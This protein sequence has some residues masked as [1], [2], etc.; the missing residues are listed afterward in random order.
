MKEEVL[1]HIDLTGCPEGTVFDPTDP[2]WS[3]EDRYFSGWECPLASIARRRPGVLRVLEEDGRPVLDHYDKT[4]R[5]LVTGDFLWTDYAVEAYVR[6]LATTS[7]PNADDPHCFVGRSGLMLRY[8]NLRQYYFFCIE[9]YERLVLYRRDHANWHVLAE[10]LVGIDPSR[11][12]RLKAECRGDLIVCSV[13]GRRCLTANDGVYRTGR[14]GIRTCTRSRFHDVKVSA[15]EAQYG[16]FVDT[17]DRYEKEVAAEREKYPGMTLWRRIDTRAFGGGAPLFGDIRGSGETEVLLLQEPAGKDDVP[18]VKAV[19]LEGKQVWEK[20]YPNL[21][22]LSRQRTLMEDIDGDGVQELVSATGE[23]MR[24]VD[25][26]TGE[27]KAEA[28]LPES[29]PFLGPRGA[30]LSEP[31]LHPL[32]ALYACNLRGNPGPQ[33]LILRDGVPGANGWTIWAYDDRLNLMWRQ[34]A[35]APWYGM[36]LWFHDVDGDGRDEVLPGHHLYD[37][38]GSLLWRMEGAE[39]IESMGD[40][41]DHAAFGELDGDE[42]NGPEIGMASS[43]EGFH[44]VDARDGKVRR[45][46][47]VGHCQ[48]V[49][50]GN[51][52]P[53]LPGLEMWMGN[54]WDNYGLLILF[55]GT[56]EQLFTFEPDNVSQGGPA[57]NWSGDGQEL[58]LLSTSVQALGM[59]DGYG[60]KVVVFPEDVP[61]PEGEPSYWPYR[62]GAQPLNLTGDVRD[63]IVLSCDGVIYIYTQ[64]AAYPKGERI[65]APIR[66]RD[67]SCPNWEVNA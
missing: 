48:G 20:D 56:G 30:Q 35:D 62:G 64:D 18:R 5:C 26:V 36:Y 57:V 66:R 25:A 58:M 50:A 9:G 1:A 2:D 24:V 41:V 67:I 11:Y 17:R 63:E 16:A 3:I 44:L 54:R 52:R 43:S 61:V 7:Q 37:D 47:R 42:S 8:R 59:Y 39:Y 38:D 6:P 51:F 13:D 49:Y 65:Y 21:K 46:H 31:Y 33:D 14:A 4:D 53:D 28:P 23:G 32:V 60:R 10:M 40:H 22:T 29:G 19:N 55:G 27:V 12:H 34:R 15:A 45:H